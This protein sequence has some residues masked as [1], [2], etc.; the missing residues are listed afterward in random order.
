MKALST[1]GCRDLQDRIAIM[2]NMCHYDIRLDTALIAKKCK[3]LRL[4]F[5]AL[6]LLN[7]DLSLLVPEAYA[8]FVNQGI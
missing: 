5:L 3:S 6:S 1:R 7:G 8:L 4:A 2:A